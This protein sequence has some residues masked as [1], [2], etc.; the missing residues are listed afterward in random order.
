MQVIEIHQRIQALA[1]EIK[2]KPEPLKIEIPVGSH[3]VQGD[4][5]IQTLAAVPT[6]WSLT[7]PTQQIAPGTTQGSRH[8]LESMDG[9]EMYTSSD[10]S[11]LD[12]PCIVAKKSFELTHPEHGHLILCP[13]V[14]RITYARQYAEELRRVA[15]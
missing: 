10:A 14:Y 4:V 15:D 9:I 3:A 11:P 13:G 1:E 2:A 8:I 5:Y 7:N 6:G 12:G